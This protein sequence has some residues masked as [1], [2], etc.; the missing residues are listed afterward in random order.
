LKCQASCTSVRALGKVDGHAKRQYERDPGTRAPGNLI[1]SPLTR[2]SVCPKLAQLGGE[3]A[4][5]NRRALR[6]HDGSHRS[7]EELGVMRPR[8]RECPSN[9][10]LVGM[11]GI[12][13]S[14]LSRRQSAATASFWY[15]A[16]WLVLSEVKGSLFQPAQR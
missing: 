10:T 4:S 8:P 5:L 7:A 16:T 9:R 6:A 13:R 14:A 12:H 11:G 15:T 1:G 3:E 2:G